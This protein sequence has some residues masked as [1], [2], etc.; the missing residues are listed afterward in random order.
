MIDMQSGSITSQ[1]AIDS[2]GVTSLRYPLL[3]RDALTG[4]TQRT[5]GEWQMSVALPADRRGTHM[6]RF[7]EELHAQSEKSFDLDECLAFAKRL[8]KILHTEAV[9]VQVAFTW[10]RLVKAPVTQKAAL[11]EQ[12]V[13]F[14]AKTIPV[15][16][17][18]LTIEVSAKALCPCSKAISDR[19][20]HNQRSDLKAVLT[21]HE[22]ALLPSINTVTELLESSASSPI[23]PIL[24]RDDEKFVTEAAY[25][26]PAF[27]EDIVRTAARQMSTLDGVSKFVVEAINRES[28][29]AHD[30]YARIVHPK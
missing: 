15:A 2:V 23:Y 3:A 17:R 11:L 19:G 10:F 7:I 25:D 4:E 9:E 21:F 13:T 26:N 20:A 14:M 8:T 16:E 29:H 12:K 5:V 18:E 22:D 6:S 30:C 28:I 27:V 24:K 1:F